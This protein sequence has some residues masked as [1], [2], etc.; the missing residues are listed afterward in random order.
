M[1]GLRSRWNL[2]AGP[3]FR[4]PSA[5]SSQTP[6]AP[7]SPARSCS[8]QSLRARTT[9]ECPRQFSFLIS[10]FVLCFFSFCFFCSFF[11]RSNVLGEILYTRYPRRAVRLHDAFAFVASRGSWVAMLHKSLRLNESAV[12]TKLSS[13]SDHQLHEPAMLQV[14]PPTLSPEP[15]TPIFRA[16]RRTP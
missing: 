9:R 4:S 12:W 7:A 10:R 16:S 6:K 8:P 1:A 3:A 13:R 15:P 14:L 2:W 11:S 5:S